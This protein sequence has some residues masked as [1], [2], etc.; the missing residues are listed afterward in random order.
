MA[1]KKRFCEYP[2]C[3]IPIWHK[4]SP[5]YSTGKYCKEHRKAEYQKDN[6]LVG[7]Q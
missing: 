3:R 4:Y 5:N 6:K 2:D 1:K 7:Y